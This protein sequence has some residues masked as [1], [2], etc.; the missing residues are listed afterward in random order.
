VSAL[1]GFNKYFPLR[2]SF[3]PLRPSLTMAAPDILSPAGPF[4]L[5]GDDMIFR[6]NL[7]SK[8]RMLRMLGGAVLMAAGLAGLQGSALG[9]AL[10][11]LGAVGVL[12]GALR[13]CP[14]CALSGRK[15][16]DT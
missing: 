3:C 15:P 14:A 9:L 6:K 11:G 12:T 5:K 1:P 8:E 13:Y 7:G 16:L 2:E 10:A 4:H